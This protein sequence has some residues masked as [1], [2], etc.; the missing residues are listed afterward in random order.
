MEV[1]EDAA[2]LPA[3]RSGD[4]EAL[5]TLVRRHQAALQRAALQLVH[6]PQDAQD[7]VQEAF[8]RVYRGRETF[9]GQGSVRAWLYRITINLAIDLVR[10]RRR[11]S[12]GPV[13]AVV[14][15][16]TP[17]VLDEVLRRERTAAV[18]AAVA[19]LPLH[20]RLPLILREWHDLRYEEIAA[21]LRI[22]VGTVRSRLHAGREALRRQ[23][24]TTWRKEDRPR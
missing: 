1:D 19:T 13:E 3:F 17:D 7:V 15:T 23:I 9:R 4:A 5:A 6:E 14:D 24:E 20:H 21:V 2:L 22:P 11:E 18:R 8:L 12:A 10:R 16:G